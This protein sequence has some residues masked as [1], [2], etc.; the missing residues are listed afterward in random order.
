MMRVALAAIAVLVTATSAMAT[1]T[2]SAQ[3]LREWPRAG[4]WSTAMIRTSSQDL[5]CY[6]A[7]APISS[8]SRSLP[9]L[10]IK[11]DD[12]AIE[13]T[14]H[15][16]RAVAGDVIRVMVDGAPVGVFGVTDRLHGFG[17]TT[18]VAEVPFDQRDQ[19]MAAFQ[20]GRSI[21]F[22]TEAARY[23]ASLA[24]TSAATA[25]LLACMD[26]ARSLA[27]AR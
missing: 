7:A 10:R 5:A 22:V 3:I 11:G 25:N 18:V 23:T 24:G 12:L 13:I 27:E 16:A 21:A 4:L 8:A 15:D 14:D 20:R 9:G 17:V 1:E 2:P 26:G 19:V 6:T